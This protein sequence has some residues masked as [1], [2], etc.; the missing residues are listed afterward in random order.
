MSNKSNI[1][2][3]RLHLTPQRIQILQ[4][5][6]DGCKVKKIAKDMELSEK[7]VEAHIWKMKHKTNLPNTIALVVCA[8]KAKIIT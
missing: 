8:L 1:Q 7:T 5:L 4:M 3:L 2:Q 6:A